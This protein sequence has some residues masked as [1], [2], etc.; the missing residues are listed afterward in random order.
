VV[1]AETTVRTNPRVPMIPEAENGKMM[2]P[3]APAASVKVVAVPMV[4]P[5]WLINVTEPV[6]EAALPFVK[7][8]ARL[9]RFTPTVSV[10][11]KPT[12]GNEK[13][14]VEVMLVVCANADAEIAT[15]S[16][17]GRRIFLIVTA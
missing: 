4:A 2:T 17:N 16:A 8:A 11:A 1:V 12:K 9:I 15:A 3:T 13:L 14:E 7:S 5:A 10:V 6:Q